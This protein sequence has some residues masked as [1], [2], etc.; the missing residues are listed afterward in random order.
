VNAANF[1]VAQ[2]EAMP[3]VANCRKQ[4][5]AAVFIIGTED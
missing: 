5:Y 4:D 1:P 3:P 2:G